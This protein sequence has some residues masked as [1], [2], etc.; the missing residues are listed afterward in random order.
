MKAE[1]LK[2]LLAALRPGEITTVRQISTKC[3]TDLERARKWLD[4]LVRAGICEKTI[5]RY[6]G[7]KRY[8][9]VRAKGGYVLRWRPI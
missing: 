9:A 1:T 2:A 8:P 4:E 5:V 3:D 7:V 6:P